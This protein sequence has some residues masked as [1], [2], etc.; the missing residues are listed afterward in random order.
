MKELPITALALYIGA[1]PAIALGTILVPYTPEYF[2]HKIYR[3]NDE[4]FNELTVKFINYVHSNIDKMDDLNTK[5]K[6]G[7][8]ETLKFNDAIIEYETKKIDVKTRQN[9]LRFLGLLSEFNNERRNT[10]Y[11]LR[12]TNVFGEL[13]TQK[14][15]KNAKNAQNAK[16]VSGGLN[17]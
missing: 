4:R 6:S 12:L 16:N 2:R 9:I 17:S 10:K 8:E 15:A 13:R 5:I 7:L 1:S 11:G 14:N 3:D